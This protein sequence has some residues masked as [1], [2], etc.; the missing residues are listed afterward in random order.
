[1]RRLLEAFDFELKRTSGSHHIFARRGVPELLNL[2]EVRGQ[3]KPYQ[4]R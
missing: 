1:M 4:I 3:V 2:Q